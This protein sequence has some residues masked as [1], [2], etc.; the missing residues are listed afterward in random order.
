M[1]MLTHVSLALM[2]Q[3]KLFSI[4]NYDLFL[5]I[6]VIINVSYSY[7]QFIT[8]QIYI[9]IYIISNIMQVIFT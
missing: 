4:N 7:L 8:Y 5:I 9:I 1:M 2:S 6:T 3:S